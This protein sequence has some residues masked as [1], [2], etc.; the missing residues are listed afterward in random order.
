M[1][2][3]RFKNNSNAG[4]LKKLRGDKYVIS[5]EVETL[6]CNFLV[7]MFIIELYTDFYISGRHKIRLA[8]EKTAGLKILVFE[9]L[10]SSS[11]PITS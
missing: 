8:F 9:L 5:E 4:V 10:K 11:H 7:Y 1:R 2:Y 3:V 6:P